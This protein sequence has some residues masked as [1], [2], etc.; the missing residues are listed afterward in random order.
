MQFD[1]LELRRWLTETMVT[2]TQQNG[3]VPKKCSECYQTLRNAVGVHGL[4]TRLSQSILTALYFHVW[5]LILSCPYA[6]CVDGH[7]YDNR[8]I[9]DPSSCTMCNNYPYTAFL[10]QIF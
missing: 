5:K 4:G 8:C 2:Q 10:M 1:R 7:T 6:D 3:G 9:I